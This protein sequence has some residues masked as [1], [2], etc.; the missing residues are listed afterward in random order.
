MTKWSIALRCAGYLVVAFPLV[1]VAYGSLPVPLGSSF[2]LLRVILVAVVLLALTYV[3]MRR[4]GRSTSE[5]GLAPTW[6]AATYLVCGL[7]AGLLLLG[8][9]ALLLRLALPLTWQ[10]NR[11][12]LP[13]AILGALVFDLFTNGCE[14]LAWRGYAFVGL[15][16]VFGHWPAQVIVAL[17]AVYFHVLS[18]WSWSVALTSTTVGSL[19]FALVFLRWRSVPAAI[20]VH[21][22]WNWGRDLLLTPGS[23]AS[24][25][26]PLGMQK[27]TRGQWDVAQA[28]LIAVPLVACAWL[29][30]SPEARRIRLEVAR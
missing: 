22:A 21:V 9:G 29:L 28:I 2:A 1:R 27:W 14:E 4:E 23:S 7:G 26:T 25:W 30:M 16:R 13:G 6:R 10:L 12:I 11:S 18:G 17:V 19:L 3:L 24:I 8:S 15:I 5:L 20:G